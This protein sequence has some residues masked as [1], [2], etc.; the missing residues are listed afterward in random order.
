MAHRYEESLAQFQKALLAD[1]GF[2]PA[3]YKLSLLYAATGRFG[4]A[5]SEFQKYSPTSGS[6]SSDSKGYIAIT[7]ASNS[8]DES[9]SGVAVAYGYAGDREK[10]FEYLEKAYSQADEELLL[11]IRLPALDFIRADPR[12]ADLMRRLGLPE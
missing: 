8:K 1:P 5:V 9:T 11:T 10:T 7:I 12:Y 3:H 2:R 4:D 6:F